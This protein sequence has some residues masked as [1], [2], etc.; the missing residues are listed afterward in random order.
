MVKRGDSVESCCVESCDSMESRAESC[1]ESCSVKLAVESSVESFSFVLDCAEALFAKL[2]C[3]PPPIC[4]I[5]S[6]GCRVA[7]N[8]PNAVIVRIT[9]RFVGIY[10]IAKGLTIFVIA[11]I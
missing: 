2:C 9:L 4:Y 6:G 3:C 5:W 7:W 11:R 8:R 1:V 10:G